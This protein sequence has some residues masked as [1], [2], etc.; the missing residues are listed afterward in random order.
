MDLQS[1]LDESE[2]KI[3]LFQTQLKNSKA[4]VETAKEETIISIQTIE[5]L[6]EELLLKS[7]NQSNAIQTPIVA[8]SKPTM[9]VIQ[10]E[11]NL[12][13]KPIQHPKSPKIFESET[14]KHILVHKIEAMEQEK[15]ESDIL[16]NETSEMV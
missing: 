13:P 9:K 6:K 15:L 16:F 1:K 5:K 2:K 8:T 3:K 7:L 11:L 4:D 10:E 12:T 14:Q